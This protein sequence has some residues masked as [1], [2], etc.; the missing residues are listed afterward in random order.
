MRTQT[1]VRMQAIRKSIGYYIIWSILEDAKK[2]ERFQIKIKTEI[3]HLIKSIT[4]GNLKK[5]K[6]CRWE[7]ANRSKSN[8]LLV[9][10]NSCGNVL[11]SFIGV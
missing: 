3:Y 6:K 1:G 5:K 4:N 11:T 7:R 2:P 10:D 9:I 8:E